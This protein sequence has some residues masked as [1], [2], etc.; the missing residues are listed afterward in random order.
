L[1]RGSTTEADTRDERAT[2][3]RARKDSLLL[4]P[5]MIDEVLGLVIGLEQNERQFQG[6]SE[7]LSKRR[8]IMQHNDGLEKK[9]N[10]GRNMF[11]QHAGWPALSFLFSLLYLN[12]GRHII[13]SFCPNGDTKSPS[14]IFGSHHVPRREYGIRKVDKQ[15]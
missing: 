3:P 15:G 4:E 7:G 10:E 2:A 14:P 8:R 6:K 13:P 1:P 12:P 9:R 5:M 11:V